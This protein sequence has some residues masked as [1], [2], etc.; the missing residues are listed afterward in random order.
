[1]GDIQY[2]IPRVC[3][4]ALF[5]ESR[6]LVADRIK[7][8]KRHSLKIMIIY[9]SPVSLRVGDGKR[10][11]FRVALGEQNLPWLAF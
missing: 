8:F 6:V 2:P 5:F 9:M 1:M 7:E 4:Y 11:V 3:V 10:E